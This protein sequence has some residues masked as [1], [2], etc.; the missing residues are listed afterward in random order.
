MHKLHFLSNK[1]KITKTMKHKELSSD[2]TV[3][4][5]TRQLCLESHNA[6]MHTGVI[7]RAVACW[8]LILLNNC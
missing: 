2:S 3:P 8:R 4:L 5:S 7:G 6:K 1:L